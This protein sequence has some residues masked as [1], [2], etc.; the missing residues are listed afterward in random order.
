MTAPSANLAYDLLSRAIYLPYACVLASS[1]PQAW[2]LSEDSADCVIT[3]QMGAN[4]TRY[5]NPLPMRE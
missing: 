4:S 1:V 5:S 2:I 3:A